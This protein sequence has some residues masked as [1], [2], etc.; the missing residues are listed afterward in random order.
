[1]N[2]GV[3]FADSAVEP[4][5]SEAVNDQEQ[6]TQEVAAPEQP[7]VEPDEVSK[8]KKMVADSQAFISQQGNMIGLMKQELEQLKS[9]Q[10]KPQEEVPEE[11]TDTDFLEKPAETVDRAVE[12]KLKAIEAEKSRRAEA[13][14]RF[15]EGNK[16]TVL[17]RVPEIK[18]LLMPMAE[19]LI[20]EDGLTHA[21]T[22]AFM[23]NLFAY[24]PATVVN[25]AHRAKLRK[26]NAELKKKLGM[27]T[28][29]GN[30]AQAAQNSSFSKPLITG[31]GG[32]S[33]RTNNSVS[34]EDLTRMSN[35]EL[36]QFYKKL[37]RK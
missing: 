6:E 15:F 16:Q 33:A 20:L 29:N 37:K 7:A 11:I 1:M 18:D 3:V 12:E 21:E 4:E 2:E 17:Q 13:Q 8:L 36:D 19:A 35:E 27:G 32:Q 25:L 28:S 31:G 22:K 34:R 10:S 5:E 9:N 24:P 14:T 26:E 23:D 30:Q